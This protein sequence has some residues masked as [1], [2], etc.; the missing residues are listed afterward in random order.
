MFFPHS[1]RVHLKCFRE[2]V[3][4]LRRKEKMFLVCLPSIDKYCAGKQVWRRKQTQQQSQHLTEGTTHCTMSMDPSKWNTKGIRVK[5]QEESDSR[6][7]HP[8]MKTMTTGDDINV[9]VSLF[10]YVIP[11]LYSSFS[12]SLPVLCVTSN[13]FVEFCFLLCV[14]L[15]SSC[16]LLLQWD[17]TC[18]CFLVVLVVQGRPFPVSLVSSS[19]LILRRFVLQRFLRRRERLSH[20]VCPTL[21]FLSL[22]GLE[23]GQD[24]WRGI[25]G[26]QRNGESLRWRGKKRRWGRKGDQELEKDKKQSRERERM[27]SK[28]GEEPERNFAPRLFALYD[29]SWTLGRLW[30]TVK[31]R[32]DFMKS[33]CVISIPTWRISLWDSWKSFLTRHVI[34]LLGIKR[35]LFHHP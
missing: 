20:S 23:G 30:K 8:K 4:N 25:S 6:K 33:L 35:H 1:G 2:K 17:R 28:E 14:V 12:F 19:Y 27:R 21:S 24:G 18:L 5:E 16:A 11:F 9:S 15:L 31:K 10:L 26:D 13:L 29:S 7:E 34:T 32:D 3:R 22:V